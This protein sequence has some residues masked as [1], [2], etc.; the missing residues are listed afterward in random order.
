MF[1]PTN[2]TRKLLDSKKL[3]EANLPWCDSKEE[4]IDVIT[5]LLSCGSM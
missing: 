5:R 2:F 4:L 3:K 1:P